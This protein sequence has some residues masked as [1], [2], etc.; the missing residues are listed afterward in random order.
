MSLASSGLEPS[1]LD[2]QLAMEQIGDTHALHGM[3]AMLEESLARDIPKIS[4]LI[5]EGDLLTANR[6]LHSIKG[7]VPIFCVEALC[8]HVASVELLSKNGEWA[9]VAKAYAALRPEL[10]LLQAEVASYLNEQGAA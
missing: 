8:Q 5:E 2:I 4:Q 10:V 9:D 7:F 3:L 1:F 6:V